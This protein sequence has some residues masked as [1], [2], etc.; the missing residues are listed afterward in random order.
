[1]FLRNY[2][3]KSFCRGLNPYFSSDRRLLKIMNSGG[4]SFDL[5]P[6]KL[7]KT[8]DS[9]DSS[10][11]SNPVF[12]NATCS[13]SP[14][15][16]PRSQSTVVK[17]NLESYRFEFL[18][19]QFL[20]FFNRHFIFSK[21]N[22]FVKIICCMFHQSLLH[23]FDGKYRN[24]AAPPVWLLLS[25]DTTGPTQMLHDSAASHKYGIWILLYLKV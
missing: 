8:T 21:M 14:A 13:I 16:M 11:Y 10:W 12:F 23:P 2:R 25:F 19:Q 1:M 17:V 9:Y 22:I 20:N 4:C 5:R 3:L 7:P 18:D 24:T 15:K 6:D